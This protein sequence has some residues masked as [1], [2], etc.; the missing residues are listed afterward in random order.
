MGM[1]KR[2][3]KED[4]TLRLEIKLRQIL[5]RI[6]QTC[7]ETRLVYFLDDVQWC[8]EES[9]RLLCDVLDFD[10]SGEVRESYNIKIVVCYAL[11]ADHLENVNI[12]HKKISF[13]DMPNKAT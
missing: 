4:Q 6:F 8:S 9:W 3:F 12:E 10:S 13:A 7:S 5:K 1:L 2:S 11:N